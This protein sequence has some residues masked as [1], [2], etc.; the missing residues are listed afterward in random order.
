MSSHSLN[1]FLGY[2][3]A[4]FTLSAL[5]ACAAACG[6]AFAQ[7]AFGASQQTSQSNPATPNG[8][9]P[10]VQIGDRGYVGVYLGD[11]NAQR[12]RDLGLKEVRG[13][14]VGRVEESSPAASAGLQE[15]DVI[16]SF[17]A[18]RVQNRAHFYRLLINSQPGSAVSLEI[19]RGGAEQRLKVV[20]GQR[21]LTG[22]DPCQ[23]LF[24]EANAHL[25]SAVES[26]KL[27][28]AAQQRSDEN[29]ARRF[30]DEE[31]TFRQLAEESRAYIEGEIR[32]GKIAECQPSR[33]PG[34]NII[35][36]RHQIGVS[37]TSLTAQLVDFFNATQD[38][39][40]ITEVKAGELSERAGL[41]AGDCIVTVGGKTVKS[42][43]D[44]DR[45]LNQESLGELEFVIVRDRS[46]RT[47]KIK[48]DQK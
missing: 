3:R 14:V 38:S 5:L 25:A 20:L 43:S 16:L 32:G 2:L 48:L 44:I 9:F 26:R 21:R 4:P 18:E 45:L 28:E 40:L 29:E 8:E 7:S 17:N 19:S 22:P 23:R 27:A 6:S 13:A 30:F 24:S 34:Y 41:K 10:P 46:R 39:V 36:D 42:A 31:K 12:A 15:N 1:R 35:P 37:L 11:L 33:R 47:V